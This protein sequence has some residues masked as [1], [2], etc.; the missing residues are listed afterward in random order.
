MPTEAR[1]SDARHA[2]YEML[3]GL[4]RDMGEVKESIRGIREDLKTN[5][6]SM[7]ARVDKIESRVADLERENAERRGATKTI[8]WLA[9]G[10]GLM[11]V[12][13]L[14]YILLHGLGKV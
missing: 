13:S 10:G 5:Q 9:G 1:V 11:G 3:A 12:A 7:V 8:L 6:T 14:L 2:D 4:T